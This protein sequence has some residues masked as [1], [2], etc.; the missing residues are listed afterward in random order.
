VIFRFGE[1]NSENVILN[2]PSALVAGN[3]QSGPIP[4]NTSNAPSSAQPQTATDSPHPQQHTHSNNSSN[5]SRA[6][7]SQHGES[8]ATG[9]GNSEAAEDT[10]N[11]PNQGSSQNP[12]PPS[13][14]EDDNIQ[15]NMLVSVSYVYSNDGTTRPATGITPGASTGND[16]QR[17]RTGSILLNV[18]NI[19]SNRTDTQLNALIEFAASIALSAIAANLRRSN[20]IKKENFEKF[21]VK[22][23]SEVVDV[24]CPICF[25]EYNEKEEVEVDDKTKGKE[26][27]SEKDKDDLINEQGKRRRRSSDE[28]LDEGRSSPRKM[29][30]TEHVHQPTNNNGESSNTSPSV[31]EP[32]SSSLGPTTDEQEEYEHVPVVLPCN[33]T[34]G[35]NCLYEW[36][37]SNSTCPLCRQRL[38]DEGESTNSAP[39]RI[40]I[41]NITSL[42]NPP[43]RG[44]P[45]V[46]VLDRSTNT[47][48]PRNNI[49]N[50]GDGA[51]AGA[52]NLTGVNTNTPEASTVSSI[53]SALTQ[54][55]GIPLAGRTPP[56]RNPLSASV[57]RG[58]DQV[59][60]FGGL[61]TSGVA[62]RRTR[63]GVETVNLNNNNNNNN[64]EE[65][66]NSFY[67]ESRRLIEERL[68]ARNLRNEASASNENSNGEANDNA[69]GTSSAEERNQERDQSVNEDREQQ[70]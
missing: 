39:Q 14:S 16:T 45:V 64:R 44:S 67:D 48:M 2:L 61:F 33:H 10:A 56:R 11:G 3:N 50:T 12:P 55:A 23:K 49:N 24:T 69:R 13:S 22:S 70:D 60:P 25:E 31:P 26:I 58:L 34:F 21:P 6:E 38:S 68:R 27:S 4:F 17:D 20:G 7:T 30:R 62:S 37:K 32:S 63:S 59:T 47:L 1:D 57:L 66:D 42:L 52:E 65:F 29:R 41:P 43:S 19:P 28:G 35:R 46:I 53:M 5:G 40:N 54:P 51:G 9:G 15:R 18:P 8:A 36:L